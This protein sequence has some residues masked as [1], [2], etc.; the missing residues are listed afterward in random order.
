MMTLATRR[1]NLKK[2][3]ACLNQEIHP[4][5]KFRQN[6]LFHYLICLP[7]DNYQTKDKFRFKMTSRKKK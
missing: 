1:K 7:D 5:I 3:P 2:K 6:Y 4:N